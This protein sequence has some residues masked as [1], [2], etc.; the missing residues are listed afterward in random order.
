M[1]GPERPHGA[2]TTLESG[3]LGARA[4]VAAPELLAR[5]GR[6]VGA[7]D[8]GAWTVRAGTPAPAV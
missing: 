8:T 3:P 5:A 7:G 4:A 6:R 1:A 2:G